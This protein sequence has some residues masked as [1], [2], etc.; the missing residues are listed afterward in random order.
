MA[1]AAVTFARALAPATAKTSACS[2]LTPAVTAALRLCLC[3]R[4]R[5]GLWASTLASAAVTAVAA[6]VAVA[7]V[8][9]VAAVTAV[10]A[11]RGAGLRPALF[12]KNPRSKTTL[13]AGPPLP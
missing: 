11:H 9:A 2:Q 13:P 3:C 12:S 10:A 7:L 8:P 5:R 6:V 4:D 1:I